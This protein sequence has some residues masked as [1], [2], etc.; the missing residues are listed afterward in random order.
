MSNLSFI[1][2][3]AFS[4]A[5]S[6]ARMSIGPIV[7]EIY[8]FIGGCEVAEYG[9]AGTDDLAQKAVKALG[10]NYAVF[11]ANHGNLCCGTTMEHAWNILNIIE[12]AAKTQL[13]ALLLGTIYAIPQEAEDKEKE[14]FD[15]MR[16]GMAS[17]H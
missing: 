16:E 8:P 4:T 12:H 3:R 17:G 13:Y 1:P 9:M 14:I 6:I 10:N 11:L 15:I 7:D 2:M 5:M